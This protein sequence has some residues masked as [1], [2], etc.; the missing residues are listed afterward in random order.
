MLS[1]RMM[2]S[3]SATYRLPFQNATPF[4]SDRPLAMILTVSAWPS[5]S[6][7]TRA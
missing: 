7:S 6:V 2:R 3:A 4:G 5:R 1:N